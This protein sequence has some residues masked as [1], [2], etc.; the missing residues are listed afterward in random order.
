MD[1]H[2]ELKWQKKIDVHLW[3]NRK[4]IIFQSMEAKCGFVDKYVGVPLKE[5]QCRSS[6]YRSKILLLMCGVGWAI[7][8]AAVILFFSLL[9]R[10]V[11]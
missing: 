7:S 11:F 9:V 8:S 10:L 1:M 6:R 5:K 3:I 4:R 2:I